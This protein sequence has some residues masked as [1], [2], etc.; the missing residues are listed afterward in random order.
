MRESMFH[1]KKNMLEGGDMFEVCAYVG[2]AWLRW[3][4]VVVKLL[5]PGKYLVVVTYC[6][7]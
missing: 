6:V 7:F 3:N 2:G 1:K 4:G 5:A